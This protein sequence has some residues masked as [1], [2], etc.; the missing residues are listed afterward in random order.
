MERADPR[1]RIGPDLPGAAYL[2]ALKDIAASH[3][4]TGVS[5]L[6]I[7][8]FNVIMF[9]LAEIPLVGLLTAP[10]ETGRRVHS[11]SAWFAA[12]GRRI[13]IALF[14]VLGVFLLARGLSN[15]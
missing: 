15:A 8:L 10:E 3:S 4:S 1:A 14:A 11:V 5:I 6:Q 7:L 13:A 2:I 12:N 9:L